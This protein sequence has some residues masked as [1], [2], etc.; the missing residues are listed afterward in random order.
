M[1]SLLSLN[2]GNN[3]NNKPNN[4][5]NITLEHKINLLYKDNHYQINFLEKK[6]LIFKCLLLQ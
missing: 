2:D 3:N 6:I 4:F 5:N 1:N